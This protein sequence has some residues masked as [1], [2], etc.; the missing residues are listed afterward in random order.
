MTFGE[1]IIGDMFNTKKCRY[2]KISEHEAIAVLSG[3][4]KIGKIVEFQS[5]DEIILLYSAI[6]KIQN[7][8]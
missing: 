2:V 8:Y 3:I 5:T 1:L 7:D 6:N 4:V